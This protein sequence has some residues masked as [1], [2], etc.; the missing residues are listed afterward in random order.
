MDMHNIAARI[1]AA[2]ADADIPAVYHGNGV[3]SCGDSTANHAST[4]RCWCVTSSGKVAYYGE[5]MVIVGEDLDEVTVGTVWRSHE[6]DVVAA[7]DTG[8]SIDDTEGIVFT[9]FSLR[10]AA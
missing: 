9:V 6:G 7:D 10:G 3:F 8:F 5:I 1:K 2:L 4:G